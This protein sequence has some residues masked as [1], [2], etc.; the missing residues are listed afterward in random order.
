M[1]PGRLCSA[2][3]ESA[4]LARLEKAVRTR[5]P[6]ADPA[7]PAAAAPGTGRAARAGTAA[8]CVSPAPRW[9]PPQTPP[10]TGTRRAPPSP[11]ARTHK[12]EADPGPPAA[13]GRA[14]GGQTAHGP[15]NTSRSPP[16]PW[17]RPRVQHRGAAGRAPP[18]P[19][20][21]T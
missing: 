10:G 17:I 2:A 8:V 14:A 20:G 16:P 5:H 13:S 9:K 4:S 11:G 21:A 1:F 6:P 3:T 12:T 18:R 19:P 15:P 7:G